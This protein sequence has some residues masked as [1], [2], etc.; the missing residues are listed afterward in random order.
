MKCVIKN[1][2]LALEISK[3]ILLKGVIFLKLVVK[4]LTLL[5]GRIERP[6]TRP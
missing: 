2:V 6:K 1:E 3:P 5:S 4:A